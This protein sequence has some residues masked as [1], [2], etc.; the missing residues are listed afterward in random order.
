MKLS[1]IERLKFHFQISAKQFISFS[2][3]AV[4]DLP[5]KLPTLYYSQITH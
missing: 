5:E 3:S 1:F 4:M 2:S